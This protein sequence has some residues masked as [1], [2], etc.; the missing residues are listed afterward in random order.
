LLDTDL[1]IDIKD[2]FV[3]LKGKTQQIVDDARYQ[4]DK[5]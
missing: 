1:E 5:Q 3:V 2:D 4:I